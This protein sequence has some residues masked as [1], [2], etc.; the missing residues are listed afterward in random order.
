MYDH[1]NLIEDDTIGVLDDHQVLDS[2]E[3]KYGF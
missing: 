3:G 1:L 2:P